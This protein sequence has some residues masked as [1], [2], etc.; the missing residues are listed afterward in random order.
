MDYSI[1]HLVDMTELLSTC[2]YNKKCNYYDSN[3]VRII[4]IIPQV[5]MQ[6]CLLQMPLI[7]PHLRTHLYAWQLSCYNG[8]NFSS[9]G[10]KL[11]NFVVFRKPRKHSIRW[12]GQLNIIKTAQFWW[13]HPLSY[14]PWFFFPKWA[15]FDPNANGHLSTPSESPVIELPNTCFSL[16][17]GHS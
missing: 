4:Y 15:H 3:S 5:N 12:Y 17:I 7:E 2:M 14:S 8:H 1:E 10:H 9:V 6:L 11:N 16:E 13:F